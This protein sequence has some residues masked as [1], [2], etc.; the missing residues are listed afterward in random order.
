MCWAALLLAGAGALHLG[1]V[2]QQVPRSAILSVG[3][4]SC[5]LVQI[6]L[7][8]ALVAIP[9]RRTAMFAVGISA[10]ILLVWP[11]AHSSGLAIGLTVWRPEALS[12]AD[13]LLP[14]LEFV[15]LGLLATVVLQRAALLR[16]RRMRTGVALVSAM[17][18]TTMLT[19]VGLTDVLND[20]WLPTTQTIHV[21]AAGSTTLEYCS[22]GGAP[23]AMDLVQ[24][25]PQAARPAPVVLY[26]PSAGWFY[27]DRQADG[28]GAALWSDQSQLNR[29]LVQRGFAVAAID[30]RQSPLHA[31]PA[32]IED[33]KCAVR[34]LRAHAA[35]LGID[36][37][38]IGTYGTSAGGNLAALL[39]TA[40]AAAQLDV[41]QD[42]DQSSAVQAVVDMYGPT[43]LDAMQDSS[44]FGQNV[45][46]F[47][48]G[49]S[50]ALRLSGS[51]MT[52]VSSDSA[53]FLILHGVDDLLVRPKHSIDL[54]Q[55]LQSFGVPAT[56]VL[57]QGTGHSM[58]TP[59]QSPAPDQIR[60]MVVDFFSH[61]LGVV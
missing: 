10:A 24:P 33:A 44:G 40:T 21:S 41:G 42:L 30:I 9:A 2:L 20:A 56:L 27:A 54:A 34:F 38:H 55:R 1:G 49:D 13:L 29:D 37:D 51:P 45:V 60:A 15:S 12:I 22:P 35:D 48:F 32:Q 31:W 11:I 52:Y 28:F 50:M 19:A 43:E 47:T 53:P 7:A 58:T 5:G 3:L 57:V 18:T 39:G 26:L 23:L 61:T 59:T 4:A 17:F 8:L 25:G 14:S 6:A 46:R 36:G 16:R